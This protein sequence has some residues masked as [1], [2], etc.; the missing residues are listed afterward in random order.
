MSSLV[1]DVLMPLALDTAYSYAVPA[2]LD[3]KEGDAVCVPLGTR[4]TVGVVWGLRAGAASNLKSVARPVDAPPMSEPMRRLV[5]WMAWYTLAPKGSVLALALKLP[6]EGRAEVA[7]IGVRLAGPA[8]KRMTPARARV[9]AAAAGGLV[10]VKRELAQAA[11][12]SAGVIDGLVDEGALETVALPPEPIAERPD[13]EHAHACLSE[14]QR[15][16]AHVLAAAVAT[17]ANP[18]ATGER[19]SAPRSCLRRAQDSSAHRVG[20]KRQVRRGRIPLIRPCHRRGEGLMARPSVV[21]VPRSSCSR[22]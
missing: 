18:L 2:G 4:E 10:H 21:L 9:L 1:A 17:F 5:D 11:S 7:R 12:V 16:A 3:L 15:A 13:P 19:S 20:G 8:P 14:A 6:E 22:A